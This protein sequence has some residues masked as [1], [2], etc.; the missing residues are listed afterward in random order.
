MRLTDPRRGAEGDE[1]SDILV[2]N[3]ALL[4]VIGRCLHVLGDHAV[5]H[6]G[7]WGDALVEA[8]LVGE[9]MQLGYS[10]R[11]GFET[12]EPIAGGRMLDAASS[13][14]T[15]VVE[16][17]ATVGQAL[18]AAVRLIATDILHDFGSP[19]VRQIAGDERFGRGTGAGTVNLPRGR[20]STE[21]K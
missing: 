16:A 18:S 3:T 17:T 2:L 7:A 5:R 14:H 19:E 21:S 13:R 15:V 6:C 20:S 11:I 9:R 10:Q 4:S 1:R 12:Y 8:R